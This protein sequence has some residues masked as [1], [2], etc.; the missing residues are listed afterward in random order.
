MSQQIMTKW[1]FSLQWPDMVSHLAT[2]CLGGTSD[3]MSAWPEAWPHVNLTQSLIF[4]WRGI[5]DVY[6]FFTHLQLWRLIY[7]FILLFFTYFL[8][9]NA[10]P[11]LWVKW[12]GMTD[13]PHPQGRH[14][15]A[16]L[17][18]IFLKNISFSIPPQTFST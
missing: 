7:L 8:S 17:Q 1:G 9:G 14:F 2:R 5:C 10:W 6:Y 4:G 12:H 11:R 18:N 16:M 13:V 3:H 15:I